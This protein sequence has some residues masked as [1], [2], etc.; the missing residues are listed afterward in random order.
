MHPPR[1]G[2]A[3]AFLVLLLALARPA[4]SDAQNLGTV[5]WQLSPFCNALTLTWT[6]EAPILTVSGFVD[7]CGGQTV[8]PTFGTG[9]AGPD[10]L[11]GVG[12]TTVLPGG[13]A[14]SLYLSVNPTTM[15]G[16]WINSV[17]LAGV[18]LPR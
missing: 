10:G 18:L 15:S 13:G 5:S 6:G 9:I 2:V 3:M 14:G 8:A 1:T 12:L 4:T 17:G 11:V 16:S 7:S